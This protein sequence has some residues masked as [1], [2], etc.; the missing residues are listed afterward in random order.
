VREAFCQTAGLAN[1]TVQWTVLSDERRELGRAARSGAQEQALCVRDAYAIVPGARMIP[2]WQMAGLIVLVLIAAAAGIYSSPNSYA[3]VYLSGQCAH[4]PMP[5][6]CHP[7]S[8]RPTFIPR[9]RP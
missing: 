9:P 4:E 1:K 6:A 2:K 5:A 7:L 8:R 3:Y